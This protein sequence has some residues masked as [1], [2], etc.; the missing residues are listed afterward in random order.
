MLENADIL[1]V[2]VGY[3]LLASLELHLVNIDVNEQSDRVKMKLVPLQCL[4]SISL[5]IISR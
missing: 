5:L 3:T 2:T 1:R 4:V